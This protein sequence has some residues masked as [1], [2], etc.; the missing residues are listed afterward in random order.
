SAAHF[1]SASNRTGSLSSSAAGGTL[2]DCQKAG[3]TTRTG[4]RSSSSPRPFPGTQGEPKDSGSAGR[5]LAHDTGVAGWL[6][7]ALG[8]RTA[9]GGG[10]GSHSFARSARRFRFDT[11]GAG[12][13]R[14]GCR[15]QGVCPEGSA[16]EG[17]SSSFWGKVRISPSGS[18]CGG[19][20]GPDLVDPLV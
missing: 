5:G 19:G 17:W 3:V 8:G 9:G 7:Q 16:G 4:F 6:L 1:S 2:G 14:A 12:E 20:K 18:F 13:A 11:P 10:G 15:S